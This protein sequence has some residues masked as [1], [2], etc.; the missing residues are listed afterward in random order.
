ME[1]SKRQ[2]VTAMSIVMDIEIKQSQDGTL[3]GKLS[4]KY[5]DEPFMFNE[6]MDMVEMMEIV[7]DTK[8]FPERQ[9]LRRTFDKS[10]K[11]IKINE[12]NLSEIAKERSAKQGARQGVAEGPGDCSSAEAS[13]TRLEA[14]GPSP[15]NFELSVRFRHKAEW[16]GS[17]LWREKGVTSSFASIV[18]LARLINE[19]LK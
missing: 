18:E 6:F 13:L 11:R 15:F 19:A 12:L 16:Q 9:L 10:K 2:R 8:G 14:E 3:V 4:C 5:F 1:H 7:F 17:L